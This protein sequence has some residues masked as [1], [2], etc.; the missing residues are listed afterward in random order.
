MPSSISP[1]ATW[2]ML[3]IVYA[4]L[5]F[6][7][8]TVCSAFAVLYIAVFLHDRISACPGPTIAVYL[9]DTLPCGVGNEFLRRHN[10]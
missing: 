8:V 10:K 6:L 9:H 1:R 3:L 5:V 4:C 2:S 7:S